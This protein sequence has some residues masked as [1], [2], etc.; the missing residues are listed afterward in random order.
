MHNA[1]FSQR[2]PMPVCR[3]TQRCP[4][5]RGGAHR[6]DVEQAQGIVMESLSNAN[7][8]VRLRDER[9]VTAYASGRMRLHSIRILPGDSV[10][11]ALTPYDPARARIVFRL[12]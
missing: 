5:R 3:G 8:R 12:R 1:G 2:P 11:V 10:V 7:F 6:H 4:R 9:M